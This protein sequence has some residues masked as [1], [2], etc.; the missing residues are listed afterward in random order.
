MN[1][2]SDCVGHNLFSSCGA[3]VRWRKGACLLAY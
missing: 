3:K 1:V 2:E